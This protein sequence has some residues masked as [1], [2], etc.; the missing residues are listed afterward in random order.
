MHC[1]TF[2]GARFIND[3]F[4]Q[5]PNRGVGERPSIVAFRVL[6]NLFFAI[7]LIKRQVL[8]L[9]Q[10]SDFEGAL[11]PLV[12]QF[13]ELFVQFINSAT[14]I[15]QVHE[16]TSRFERPVCAACLSKRMRDSRAAA[17]RSTA[18]EELSFAVQASISETKADPI[19]A[20]SARPPSTET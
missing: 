5:T 14:P 18:V 19:T 15:T 9:L 6:Q 1:Q 8:L 11:R 3:S 10:L 4:E 16:A 13:H 12:Q 7:G 2:G 17:A 20:A